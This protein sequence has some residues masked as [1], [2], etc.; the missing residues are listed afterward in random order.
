MCKCESFEGYNYSK[1]NHYYRQSTGIETCIFTKE[2]KW[3]IETSVENTKFSTIQI[4]YC[5]LC[6]RKL[7]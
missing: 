2:R 3:F 4:Y 7:D 1:L 5:P 6:G